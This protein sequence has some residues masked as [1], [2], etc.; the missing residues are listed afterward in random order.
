MP[1]ERSVAWLSLERSDSQPASYWTYLIT[2]LQAVVPGVGGSALQLLQSAPP[3][4]TV[5]TTALNELG[6]APNDLYL[7]LDDY[8]LVDSPE[9]QDGRT[10]LLEHLPPQAHLVVST[11]EDRAL[12]LSRLPA[13]SSRSEP[14][15]CASPSTR[16]RPTSTTS[17]GSSW[18]RATS[19]PWRD[20]P[21]AGSPRSSWRRCRCRGETTSPA[22]SPGSPGTT[23]TSR[24][25][26][27]PI[28]WTSTPTGW[29]P[30]TAGPASGT[31]RTRSHPR[32]SAMRW[33]PGT[34]SEQRV[35]SSWRS[36]HCAGARQEATIRGW[37]DAIPGDVV[38]VRP[39]LAVGFIGALMAVGSSRRR[40]PAAGRR[41]VAGA[42]R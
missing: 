36:R 8:H 40:G 26:C 33:P 15:T 13:S 20:A 16:R 3:I 6:A 23:G 35:W 34:S 18:R 24:T 38:R 7:V 2:A 9:V 11:R 41:A 27:S 29:R 4:E 5:L 14:L 32:R 30:C 25:S 28:S 39:V 10:F 22:S 12:P 17:P 37:L 21:K 19:R 42:H 1:T 31:S